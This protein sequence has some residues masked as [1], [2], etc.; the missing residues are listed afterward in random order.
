MLQLI[1]IFPSVF[2]DIVCMYVYVF[3]AIFLRI[4]ALNI[5]SAQHYEIFW[6]T[7]CYKCGRQLDH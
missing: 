4:S 6:N 5:Y 3:L 7:L 2:N 1:G